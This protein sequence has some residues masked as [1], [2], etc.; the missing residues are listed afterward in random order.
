[1]NKI[2]N[3]NNSNDDMKIWAGGVRYTIHTAIKLNEI[4]MSNMGLIAFWYGN[5]MF[6]C[7]VARCYR[8]TLR[9]EISDVQNPEISGCVWKPNCK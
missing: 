5:D 9:F 6:H 2:I 8:K 7:N 4:V 3:N 1:M